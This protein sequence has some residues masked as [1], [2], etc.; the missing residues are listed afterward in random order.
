MKK[1][2]GDRA[3]SSLRSS[4]CLDKPQTPTDA[5]AACRQRITEEAVA[6][7][8]ALINEARGG[9]YQAA[10]FLFEFAG[11]MQAPAPE[12]SGPQPNELVLAELKRILAEERASPQVE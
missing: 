12:P 5:A 7:T 6:I 9:S 8:D 11:L 1:R 4:E 10:K 2:S 3:S